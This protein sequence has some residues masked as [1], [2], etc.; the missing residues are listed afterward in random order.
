MR[1]TADPWVQPFFHRRIR[2][3]L[4]QV[5]T[6]LRRDVPNF[7]RFGPGAPRYVERIW[8]DAA[9]CDW[10]M[11]RGV[12]TSYLGVPQWE[13]ASAV[14]TEAPWPQALL[15]PVTQIPKFRFCIAHWVHG[16]SWRE[17]GAYEYMQAVIARKGRSDGC[18][19]MADVVAR[20]D[21]LDR[22][23]EEACREKRLRPRQ[24]VHPGNWREQGGPMFHLGPHGALY[25]ADG[26]TH[27]FAIARILNL[28]M[29]AR[30][31]CVHR[32]ALPWLP[33]IREAV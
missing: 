12:A 8:V 5:A 19:T 31:G 20:Y 2:G 24:E 10:H 32:S 27:R 15:V 9:S 30:L 28:R 29:P 21:A 3:R 14:V 23:F 33:A 13:D 7:C 6:G 18:Q 4:S 16:V 1:P 17:T 25:Y 22:I 26:G 11:P